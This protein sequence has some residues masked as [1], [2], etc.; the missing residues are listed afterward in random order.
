MIDVNKF[1]KAGKKEGSASF[2][3]TIS[4]VVK[5]PHLVLGTVERAVLQDSS[6]GNSPGIN[7]LE[8]AWTAF[9]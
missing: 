7:R 5:W 6:G 3:L 8:L 4:T 2:F 9:G 1:L